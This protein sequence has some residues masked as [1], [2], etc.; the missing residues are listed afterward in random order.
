MTNN[1]ILNI[2]QSLGKVSKLPGVKFSY[3]VARN[4]NLIRPVIEKYE[5]ARIALLKSCTK[6]DKKGEVE[7]DDKGEPIWKDEKTW[8]IEI[9]KL[10]K[11]EVQEVK[12]YKI[13]LANVPEQ[14]T[15]EQLSGIYEL[16]NEQPTA[17]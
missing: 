12:F 4:N 9:E 10:G 3:F 1:K 2:A 7:R 8:I 15:G 17:K 11:E 6:Q 13:D 16:I 14:I 5:E